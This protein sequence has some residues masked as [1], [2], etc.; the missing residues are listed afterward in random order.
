MTDAIKIQIA[1]R[2]W[3]EL[4]VY[5]EVWTEQKVIIAPCS[6]DE[7]EAIVKIYREETTKESDVIKGI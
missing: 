6:I 4:S 2:C 1:E 5:V 7:V 3:D